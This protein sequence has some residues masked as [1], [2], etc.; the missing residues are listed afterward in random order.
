MRETNTLTLKG[1]LTDLELTQ[2]GEEFPLL[3]A[4]LASDVTGPR[5]LVHYW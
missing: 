5:S 1:T 3:R 2:V 4:T